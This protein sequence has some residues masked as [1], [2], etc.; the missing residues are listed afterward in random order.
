MGE[1]RV[2]RKLTT[3]LSADGKGYSRLMGEDE[4]ASVRTSEAHR[5]HQ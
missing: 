5:E 3:I 4:L 1:E 2:N